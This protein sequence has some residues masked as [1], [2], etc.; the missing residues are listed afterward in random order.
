[1]ALE[2]TIV[3]EIDRFPA[4]GLT[5]RRKIKTPVREITAANVM[6]VLAK[7]L[8][9]HEMNA[10]E[11]KY[12]W[13]YYRGKQDIRLKE[14]YTRENINNKVVVNRA[15]QIVTFKTSY[16]LNEPIS[17]NSTGNNDSLTE[18]VNR[19]NDYMR[20]EDK[21]SKD[22][23]IVDWMHICGI[24]ERLT[25]TD[26]MAGVDDGASSIQ[27]SPSKTRK[28]F[29]RD[30]G[31]PAK[32]FNSRSKTVC[33]R[34]IRHQ[35][36]PLSSKPFLKWS[37]QTAKPTVSPAWSVPRKRPR[38]RFTWNTATRT[39]RAKTER[40]P[41]VPR[42]LKSVPPGVNMC[43]LSASLKSPLAAISSSEAIERKVR[44]STRTS[45]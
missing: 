18:N 41:S 4:G 20:S 27:N 38:H 10:A 13:D 43:F 19:L 3:R 42:L 34:S 45:S 33:S 35:T 21:E 29:P 23:E 36:A 11:I 6:D 1:M 7:A 32:H 8:T 24:G 2:N 40:V 14:K 44:Y 17:Y 39:R 26:E 30:G 12:L 15:N 22:K 31:H 16:L 5:G 28:A 25:L 9:I 37:S